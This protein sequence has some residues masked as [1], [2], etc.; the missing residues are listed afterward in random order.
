MGCR[1]YLFVNKEL[2]RVNRDALDK[3]NDKGVIL[4][5]PA[6]FAR[7]TTLLVLKEPKTKTSVRKVFIPAT[8]AEML[9]ERHRE[10][11]E[12][13]E[14]FGDE[15]IEPLISRAL[16]R[17]LTFLVEPLF[18]KLSVIVPGCAPSRLR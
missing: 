2:Q 15:F 3:L 6:V 17:Y 4:K 7:N 1:A 16:S 18:L 13:K 11:E 12:Y 5:F 9:R 14:L 10:L 8:V